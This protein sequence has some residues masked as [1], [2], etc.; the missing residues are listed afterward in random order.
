MSIIFI[1]NHQLTTN[2]VNLPNLP[3]TDHQSPIS[4]NFLFPYQQISA[5][6]LHTQ[7]K[8]MEPVITRQNKTFCGFGFMNSEN[9]LSLSA[10][11]QGNP[12]P[13]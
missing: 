9:D 3:H 10:E 4:F 2:P 7:H 13:L 8:G 5:G 6:G 11:K 12:S 1:H